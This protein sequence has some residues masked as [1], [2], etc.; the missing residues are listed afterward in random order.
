MKL[1][2]RSP[3]EPQIN[4]TSL[5]DVVFLLLIFFMVTTTFV[6][7]A[8]LRILLPEAGGDIQTPPQNYLEIVVDAAD[9]VYVRGEPVPSDEKVL[10][11]EL[12]NLANGD[13]AR[14]LRLRADG[15]A[16]HQAVVQVMDI[17]AALGFQR[18]DIATLA[19]AEE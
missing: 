15:R 8:G 10:R 19:S 4:L 5:I 13:F 7:D 17:A 14:P 16:S 6:N 3:E 18:V 12:Q 9:R 11:S 1:A 2:R